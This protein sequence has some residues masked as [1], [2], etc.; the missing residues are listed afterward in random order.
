MILTD[1]K[2]QDGFDITRETLTRDG[3]DTIFPKNLDDMTIEQL[4]I[5]ARNA[6]IVGRSKLTKKPQLIESIKKYLCEAKISLESLCGEGKESEAQVT[7]ANRSGSVSQVASSTRNDNG[8]T[9][10]L[11]LGA[12]GTNEPSSVDEAIIDSSISTGIRNDTNVSADATNAITIVASTSGDTNP[13]LCPVQECDGQAEVQC[14]TCALTFCASLH[15]EHSSHSCQ[16]LKSGFKFP[17]SQVGIHWVAPPRN[18]PEIIN[19]IA[20]NDSISGTKHKQSI[21]TSTS[22]AKLQLLPV[23]GVSSCETSDNLSGGKRKHISP[24]KPAA[25]D[26]SQSIVPKTKLLDT[27]SISDAKQDM[28]GD[29]RHHP[30]TYAD[31]VEAEVDVA[32]KVKVMLADAGKDPS[33]ELKRLLNYNCYDVDFLVK[34][35]RILHI[36]ISDAVAV[37]RATREG[38]MKALILKLSLK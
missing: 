2:V 29:K 31:S 17:E 10:R 9:T 34:L 13:L 14:S 18:G 28:R 22:P 6:K 32:S 20:L 16:Q 30:S 37:R 19:L 36:D 26:S 5:L 8:P 24:L 11:V 15:G 3:K 35:S 1:I 7:T 21:D 27:S 12:G 23:S 4:T 25:I 38:V 33:S